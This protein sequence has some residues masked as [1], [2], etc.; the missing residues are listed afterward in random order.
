MIF[1]AF[2]EHANGTARHAPTVVPAAS[3][4]PTPQSISP[5]LA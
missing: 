4:A 1:R 5:A 2:T 3:Q